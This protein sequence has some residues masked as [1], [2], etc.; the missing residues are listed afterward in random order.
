MRALLRIFLPISGLFFPIPASAQNADGARLF[1][2]RCA[3]CHSV[4]AGRN[5]AGPHLSGLIGRAAG[6]AEGATYSDAMRSSGLTWD[7]QSLDTF[8]TAP[9]RMVRGTRMTVA[10]PNATQRA[11]IIKYLDG[12]SAD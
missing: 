6:T 3:T 2:Q 10:V 11:A 1:Q 9:G 12:Q 7:G 5:K 8:L 4:E